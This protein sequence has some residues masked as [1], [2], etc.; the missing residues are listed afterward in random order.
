MNKKCNK[1]VST[2]FVFLIF[3][4]VVLSSSGYEII[5][6]VVSSGGSVNSS[7]GPYTNDSSLLVFATF[8]HIVGTTEVV[9][10]FQQ[11]I[12]NLP[13]VI[14]T[15]PYNDTWLNSRVVNFSW[16]YVDFDGHPQARYR[17]YI[18]TM[19]D[20]TGYD[21]GSG[22]VVS[23]NNF[24]TSNVLPDNT[25]YWMVGCFDNFWYE[26]GKSTYS[27][28]FRIDTSSP[29][30]NNVDFQIHI[31]SILVSVSAY[32]SGIGLHSEAYKFSISTTAN[33]EPNISTT[34]QW[35]SASSHLFTSLSINT[36]Y[37]IKVYCRDKFG[38]TT[39]I[40]YTVATLCN[41]PPGIS[42]VS[43]STGSIT[44]SW[45][46]DEDP[47]NPLDSVYVLEL[48]SYTDF[49]YYI[50]SIGRKSYGSLSLVELVPNSTYYMRVVALNRVGLRTVSQVVSTNT[51]SAPVDYI[52][53][54]SV[55]SY[56]V[57]IEWGNNG[58]PGY[59]MYEVLVSSVVS[60][61]Y[62]HLISTTSLGYLHT[63]L[64]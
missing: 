4:V 54:V 48:S 7:S 43:R 35:F 26:E 24:Y 5:T 46:M 45:G 30:I 62:E 8:Y 15:T 28:C 58:N 12:N 60:D 19:I 39:E 25:Y 51:L 61:R 44:V 2:I 3:P 20:F 57:R 6:D 14:L 50:S 11:N 42:V 59:T 16:G 21:Y 33:F 52:R 27:L 32:D 36:T 55:S 17:V 18:S 13:L 47:E 9:S 37:F 29:V 31:S 49:Y 22:V 63:G 64:S 53:F 38:H 10:G 34:T 23:S 40:L 1:I 56:S 41:I